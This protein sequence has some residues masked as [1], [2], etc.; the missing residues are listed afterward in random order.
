MFLRY[1]VITT[2]WSHNCINI[3]FQQNATLYND[4]SLKTQIFSFPLIDIK[5]RLFLGQWNLMKESK[6]EGNEESH[7]VKN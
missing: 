4:S 5:N 2:I 7:K 6:V 3:F 1:R